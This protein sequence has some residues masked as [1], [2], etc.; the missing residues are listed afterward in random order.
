MIDGT[1]LPRLGII[2]GSTRPG[3]VALPLGE[4][5]EKL[6]VAAGAFEASL[7]DLADIGLPFLDEPLHPAMRT[8]EHQHSRDWSELVSGYDAFVIVSPEYN[9]GFSAPLKNALDYLFFEWNYKPVGVVSYGGVS[10]GT[11]SAQMLKLVLDSLRLTPVADNVHIPFVSEYVIDGNVR[12][13]ELMEGSAQ[14]M[15]GELARL[16]GALRPLRHEARLATS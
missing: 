6:A 16:E 12:A 9:Y 8:Y 11:R 10:A 7:I 1:A 4:W 3:R 15:L 5:V 2:I 14:R 13:N